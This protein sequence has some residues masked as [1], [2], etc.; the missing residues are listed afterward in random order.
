VEDDATM[1]L[2]AA[3]IFHA[4]CVSKGN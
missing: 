4:F 2:L 1:L 3:G